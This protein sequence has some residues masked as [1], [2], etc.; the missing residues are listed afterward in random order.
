[1]LCHLSYLRERLQCTKGFS[2]RQHLSIRHTHLTCSRIM[3]VFLVQ[4][5]SSTMKM[6]LPLCDQAVTR[7]K[8]LDVSVRLRDVL[9]FLSTYSYSLLSHCLLI[10]PGRPPNNLLPHPLHLFAVAPADN[11]CRPSAK[12]LG[13]TRDPPLRVFHAMRDTTQ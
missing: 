4:A 10:S 9:P 5:T 12:V 8:E 13:H 2:Y 1:M 7:D 11:T 3:G 6:T